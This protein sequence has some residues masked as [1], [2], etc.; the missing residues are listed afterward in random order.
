MEW[1]SSRHRG[2]AVAMALMLSS[3]GL[4]LAQVNGAQTADAKIK[5]LQSYIQSIDK[6]SATQQ[7]YLSSGTRNSYRY[8]QL[9]IERLQGKGPVVKAATRQGTGRPIGLR[10]DVTLRG[11]GNPF[12]LGVTPVNDQGL[13]FKQSVVGGYAQHE[14]S[15]AWCGNSVVVG[16]EDAGAYL[17]TR[18]T[19]PAGPASFLNAGASSDGG[20]TF[21]GQE[22]LNPGTDPNAALTGNPT[23]ACSSQSTFYYAAQYFG[24]APIGAANAQYT[25]SIAVLTS[26]NGGAA[27]GAPKL[28]AVGDGVHSLGSPWIAADPSHPTT[29][30]LTYT[31]LDQSDLNLCNDD[32][33]I[34]VELIA[35]HDG[36]AT[37][38]K[39]TVPAFF[40]RVSRETP[41]SLKLAV[42]RT[43]KVYLA[44]EVVTEAGAFG[45]TAI[46]VG[47]SIDHGAT[48][49]TFQDVQDIQPTGGS[50]DVLEGG[51]QNN[52]YPSLAVDPSGTAVYVA[53]ADGPFEGEN[54]D[55][56]SG[57]YN[58]S[59]VKV[60]RSLDGGASW[61]YGMMVSPTPATYTG[62]GRDQ[63]EP[64][65][66]VDR[67]GNVV[68]CY[69]DRRNDPNN[70]LIDRYC[71]RSTD[72]GAT[73]VDYKKTST[74]FLSANYDAVTGGFGDYDTT[75]NDFT[76]ANPGVIGGFQIQNGGDPNVYAVR[77]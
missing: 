73:W 54:L 2:I 26:Q 52:G 62:R 65:I 77:F 33:T 35:S 40:C 57:V 20:R 76:G 28:A 74:S 63:F 3:T 22:F 7:R 12:D 61:I 25:N 30:Y 55:L 32:Y 8:A 27:W 19:N 56:V 72:H 1:Q 60:A 68:V 53:W 18:L 6:L 15:T 45:P 11:P 10:G 64:A 29:L 69:Y 5:Q 43:G 24:L 23:V 17:R 67:T 41:E 36:G 46:F 51:I 58:Y 71:S 44:F 9:E 37:W 16:F 4:A 42:D 50:G 31:D 59:D 75:V 13:D 70:L 66:G 47:S 14:S 34:N 38:S 48:F 49:S 21:K 39:P